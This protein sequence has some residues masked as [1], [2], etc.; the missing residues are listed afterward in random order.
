M[1]IRIQRTRRMLFDAYEE[2]L[3][4]MPF[5][6]IS[7]TDICARSTVNRATFYRHFPD[8][9]AFMKAFLQSMTDRFLEH[10]DKDAAQLGL[11]EY[12]RHMHRE[13]ISF[14]NGNHDL[15]RNAMGRRAEVEIIDMLT[16]QIAVGIFEHLDAYARNEGIELDVPADFAALYYAGGMMQTLRW[17]IDAGQPIPAEELERRCTAGL[18]AQVR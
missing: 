7:V 10:I 5:E 1:D 6:K 15:A 16:R 12:A 17:W 2:L 13:L 8:R 14:V 11:E 3:G 18:M 4:E 9:G